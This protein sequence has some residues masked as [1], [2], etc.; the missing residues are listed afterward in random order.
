MDD[1]ALRM[2]Q[3]GA[4][5]LCCSQILLQLAL[6]MQGRE[7]PGLVRAMA[8][9][10]NGLGDCSGPCGALSGGACLLG[11]YAGSA[12]DD[13]PADPASERLPLMLAQLVEWFRETVGQRHGGVSCGEILGDSECGE[14][15]PVLCGSIVGDTFARCLD[16][17]LENGF[18]P[19]ESRDREQT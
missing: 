10:G 17:L 11:L 1:V 18:D 2:M 16:I 12:L 5:G 13:A 15:D 7:N 8:G 6:E 3:L 14:P 4:R 9:L 19:L